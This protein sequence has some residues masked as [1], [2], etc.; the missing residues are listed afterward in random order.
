STVK[1]S[2]GAQASFLVL[3]DVGAGVDENDPA[4]V[5][6]RA[7]HKPIDLD[8]FPNSSL[9]GQFAFPMVARG[10]LLGALVCGN[11]ADSEVY[12]PDESE[13]LQMLASGVGSALGLF[14][15]DGSTSNGSLTGAI[16]EL[17]AIA[18]DLR[19]L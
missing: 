10:E 16:E 19:G 4:L 15:R 2:T 8:R 17:R 1:S 12:A 18:R 11:K 5:A 6:L 7:W 13:A 9:H 3:D 14:S